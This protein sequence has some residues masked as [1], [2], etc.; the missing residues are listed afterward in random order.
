MGSV[1]PFVCT[2]GTPHAGTAGA[3][4]GTRIKAGFG[5]GSSFALGSLVG[6]RAS[7]TDETASPEPELGSRRRSKRRVRELPP[8]PPVAAAANDD[9][10]LGSCALSIASRFAG[11]F[12]SLHCLASAAA[13]GDTPR[14]NF[15]HANRGCDS[16]TAPFFVRSALCADR[17]TAATKAGCASKYVR[18]SV[19]ACGAN[20]QVSSE[21]STRSRKWL[22]PV[23][24]RFS[25]IGRSAGIARTPT[26]ERQSTTTPSPNTFSG[27]STSDGGGNAASISRPVCHRP[28]M[29]PAPPILA[30]VPKRGALCA[31][32]ICHHTWTSRWKGC[33]FHDCDDTLEAIRV[34]VVLQRYF[35]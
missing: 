7:A 35:R 9:L 25:P 10:P 11:R 4:A 1:P 23:N 33:D 29:G 6:G 12:F 8:C 17:T 2:R 21:P 18:R 28:S 32:S 13:M 16:P 27:S 3:E 22:E 34:S 30:Q 31:R 15:P 19:A 5:F 20:S 26:R 14:M 24:V